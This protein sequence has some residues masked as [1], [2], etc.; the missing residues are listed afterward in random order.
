MRKLL[1]YLGGVVIV[2]VL[3]VAGLFLSRGTTPII[4]AQEEPETAAVERTVL[5]NTI[6]TTGTIAPEQ[7]AS[8]TFDTSG[9]VRE[10]LVEVGDAVTAGQELAK[11]DTS[12]LEYQVSL[13][14]QSLIVQQTNYD[15]LVSD[16]TDSEIAQAEANLASA[17]SQLRSA[18]SQLDAAPN[19]ATI[20]CSSLDTA[21][22]TLED[23]QGDYDDYVRDG[24]EWDAT[25]IP[26]TD[27]EWGQ[28]LRDAQRTYDVELAQCDNTTTADEY[29]LDVAAAQASVDQ[30]Q[31]SL[32]SLVNGPTEAEINQAE[33]QL[34]QARLEMENAQTQLL[35]AVLVAPF[36]GII[37][38]NNLVV[39]Q[40][41]SN[42][43]AAMTLIDTSVLHVDVDVDEL[44]I[45]QV[46][47]GQTVIVR[48]DALEDI[49]ISGVVARIAPT[50]TE[51][52]GIVTYEVRV[53]LTNLGDLPVRVGMTTEV[54]IATEMTGEVLAV[55]TDAIQREGSTEYVEVL[56]DDGTITRV[57]VVTGDSSDGMTAVEGDLTEGDQVIIP[58]RDTAQQN[59]G[60][61]GP[62]GGGQ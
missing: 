53:D 12:D 18:Q 26:D 16:P 22:D 4:T 20:N 23:A 25:F 57:N 46:E 19:Q 24:F 30:A 8:L 59:T 61:G 28:A 45:A 38:A 6:E 7:T 34:E 44:D 37:S 35:D 55:P 42:G 41:T 31:A 2:G 3:V 11:L 27:S 17:Q 9:V 56:G 62:L 32:D 33:A 43:A 48:A 47:I 50:G 36:D 10:V 49:T 58:V 39:G 40:I 15:E 51:T 13:Q 5:G 54:E 52:D 21:R 29:E 14:Q 1:L 60:F